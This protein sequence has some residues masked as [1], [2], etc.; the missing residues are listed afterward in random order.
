MCF[1]L[2]HLSISTIFYSLRGLHAF[3]EPFPWAF[4]IRFSHISLPGAARLPVLPMNRDHTPAKL[5]YLG[6]LRVG[7]FFLLYQLQ[8]FI[9]QSIAMVADRNVVGQNHD[10]LRGMGTG[11]LFF[12][13]HKIDLRNCSYFLVQRRRLFGWFYATRVVVL[14]PLRVVVLSHTEDTLNYLD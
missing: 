3:C 8:V 13:R 14:E 4:H 11:F 10:E 7:Y 1:P 5:S 2:V 9:E 12:R 6:G